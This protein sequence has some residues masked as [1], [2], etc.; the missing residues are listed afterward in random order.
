[1]LVGC[2]LKSFYGSLFLWDFEVSYGV[3]TKKMTTSIFGSI[4]FQLLNH[5]FACSLSLSAV[6]LVNDINRKDK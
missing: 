3:R 5:L 4:Q 1:M 6:G 2:L